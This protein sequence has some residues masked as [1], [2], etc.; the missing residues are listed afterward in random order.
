LLFAAAA[1]L[2]DGA[3]GRTSTRHFHMSERCTGSARTFG[4]CHAAVL[5]AAVL[6]LLPGSGAAISSD[7]PD[8]KTVLRRAAD[9]T[10]GYHE[11]LSS[12]VAEERYVQRTGPMF[13]NRVPLPGARPTDQER[14]LRSDFVIVRGVGVGS[15]WLGVREVLEVDGRPV[16]GEH[17][18][19]EALLAD[20]R[21]GKAARLRAL[22]DAQA[23]FNLGD[24]YRTI[25][26]PTLAL[27]FLL[28]D[29][30]DRFRF[31]RSGT[32][33]LR[34]VSAWTVSF[35]ERT[36]PTLIQTPEGRDVVSKGVFWIEPETGAVL[37]T[38]L[39]TGEGRG[40]GPHSIILVSYARNERFDMLLP[41]DM[42]EL[43]LT[44]RSRIEGHA[45]YSRFRRFETDVRIK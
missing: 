42:N 23:R 32:A 10:A 15:P 38:E 11:Q 36:R 27:E 12:I 40:R 16:E 1:A 25:N 19:I 43:Y 24:L 4:F 17:G 28:Q 5:M 33:A 14:V 41:D 29:R 30:Q 21:S 45:S 6:V 7:A 20:T 8:L 3:S 34:G 2:P 13:T 44:G 31:K 22:A 26:V 35:E 39:R 37:R 9:Y 18:R